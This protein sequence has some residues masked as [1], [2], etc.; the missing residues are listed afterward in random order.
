MLPTTSDYSKRL[1]QL[2]NQG[3]LELTLEGL[4][5]IPPPKPPHLGI[6]WDWDRMEGMLLGLA[7]GDA[8]GNTVSPSFHTSAAPSMGRFA[9]IYPIVMQGANMWGCRLMTPKWPS[10]RLSI[11]F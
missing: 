7:I 8:L 6:P 11:C 10:G 1:R 3:R 2:I 9:T 5:A 4:G